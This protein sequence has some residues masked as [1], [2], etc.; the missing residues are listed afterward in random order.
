MKHDSREVVLRFFD[1]SA[2]CAWDTG[3]PDATGQGR[4]FA[5]RRSC[6]V[7]GPSGHGNRLREM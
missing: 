3:C 4:S 6:G 7:R 5:E 1:G 2:G